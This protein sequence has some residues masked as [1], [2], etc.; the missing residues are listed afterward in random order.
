MTSQAERRESLIDISVLVGLPAILLVLA[1]LWW[2][3]WRIDP[4]EIPSDKDIF[5]VASGSWD[6]VNADS[7]CVANPYE[8][9]FNP[10]HSLMYVRYGRPEIDSVGS[11]DSGGTYDVQEHSRSYIRGLMHNE[12]RL[13][14]DGQPAVWDLVIMSPQLMAWRRTDWASGE[15]T[16]RIVRCQSAR[17]STD[18]ETVSDTA[19]S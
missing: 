6:W 3:P 8:I 12:A 19:G 1:I 11:V 13:T 7:L 9:S 4:Y 18:A 15:Y 2:H 14:A 10:D 17:T 16:Q 5:T